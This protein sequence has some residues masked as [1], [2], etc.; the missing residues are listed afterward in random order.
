MKYALLAYETDE[1]FASRTSET[2]QAEYWASWM[3]YSEAVSV[4]NESGAA[5]QV[6]ATATAVTV[7]DG[8]RHVQDGPYPDTKEQ[9]GGFFLIDVPDLD[10]ALEWAARCP[11]AQYATVEV[12]PLLEM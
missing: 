11:A 3:A 6:P 4:V 9:L 1:A 5:L 2:D 8:E 10:T 7:R 12:R